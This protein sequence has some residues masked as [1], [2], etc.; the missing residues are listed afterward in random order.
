MRPVALQSVELGSQLLQ[1][2]PGFCFQ[3]LTEKCRT[4]VFYNF[5]ARDCSPR[6]NINT[7]STHFIFKF[8]FSLDLWVLY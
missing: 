4:L 2:A 7:L 1:K 3:R 5:V 6:N 8:N